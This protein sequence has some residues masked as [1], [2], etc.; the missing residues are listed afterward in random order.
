MQITEIG[1]P[2]TELWRHSASLRASLQTRVCSA[3]EVALAID[4][5]TAVA[6]S[7]GGFIMDA[8]PTTKPETRNQ[9]PETDF[10]P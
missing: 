9:E 7:P 8:R 6:F 10:N 5:K 4:K 1:G 2:H 3:R